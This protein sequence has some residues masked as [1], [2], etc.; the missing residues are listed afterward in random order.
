MLHLN[1]PKHDLIKDQFFQSAFFCALGGV[2][3]GV[4]HI[5]S[6]FQ[7]MIYL[8]KFSEV[9]TC[10]DLYVDLFALT[11]SSIDLSLYRFRA[12]IRLIDRSI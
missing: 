10:C 7:E 6:A 9:D 12:I 11:Y 3:E 4:G 8:H 2:P 1:T 5:M